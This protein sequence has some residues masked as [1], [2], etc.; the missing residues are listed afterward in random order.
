MFEERNK[1]SSMLLEKI[2]I[3]L[4][5]LPEDVSYLMQLIDNPSLDEDMKLILITPINYLFKTV[6]LIPDG[7]DEI[8]YIDDSILLRIS[9]KELVEKYGDKLQAELYDRLKIMAGDTDILKQ[10][11][12]MEIWTKLLSYFEEL[13]ELPARG[14]LPS[15]ILKDQITYNQFK[16]EIK[17]ILDSYEAKIS[18][19]DEKTIIKLKAFLEAKLS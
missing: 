15:D 19:I 17:A 10:E 5:N 6:D 1:G 7:L 13:K 2:P 4:K 9:C 16:T 8:G 11:L 18:Q 14:R 3:W 12:G